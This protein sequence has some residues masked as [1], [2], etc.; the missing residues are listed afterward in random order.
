MSAGREETVLPPRNGEILIAI[1]QLLNSGTG[2]LRLTAAD[3]TDAVL[4]DELR[5]VLTTVVSSMHR[6]Q[7]VTL[8]P[9]AMRLTT[10]QAADLLGISRPT[11]VKLLE[12]GRIPFETPN[13]HRRIRLLDLLTFQQA[14]RVERRESLAAM[15]REAQDLG[16]YEGTPEDYEAALAEA[17]QKLA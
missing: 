17:R 4:P 16:T 5:R 2:P 12:E 7:A 10:Q 15:T 9:R 3:G 14:R 13:R 8:A 11:L 1:E 6:G